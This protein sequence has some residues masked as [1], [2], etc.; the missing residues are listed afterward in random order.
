M[1]LVISVVQDQDADRSIAAL[2]DA[3]YRVTRVASTGGFFREG[4]T[5]LLSGVQDANVEAVLD[6]LKRT[7]E[8]RT[9]LIAAGPNVIESAA[10]MGS[11]MEVEVGGAIIFVLDVEHFEQT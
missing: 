11:L 8:R 1:K 10:M 7:C 9:R 3:G 6:I 5:T 4:N 2:N